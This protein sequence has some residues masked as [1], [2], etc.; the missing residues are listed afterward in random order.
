M[1]TTK[2][3]TPKLTGTENIKIPYYPGC[4]L[5]TTAK[6]FENSAVAAARALGI[7]LLEIPRWNCCGTVFSLTDDDLIHHVA[8]VRNFIRVQEMNDY[9]L[10][11]NENRLVTLC[12][13]CFN[14]LKS[15][16]LRVKNNAE[17][18]K[19]INDLMYREENYGGKVEVLH[20][21]EL[22][23]SLGFE[24]IRDRVK[25]PLKGLKIA[26][27]YGCMILRPQEIGIDDPE[28][29]TIQ[30]DLLLS[31]GADSV[32]TPYKRVC[33]G[34]Y[35]TVKEKNI[36]AELAYDIL[37]HARKE[38]AEAMATV[39]PLCAFNLDHRQ[40]EVKASHSDFEEIPVFYVT[41]LMAIAF[42]LENEC[43][44]FDQNYVDPRPLLASKSLI[45]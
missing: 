4:T 7:E 14:T 40:K 43:Y 28:D 45:K 17:D 22:L 3:E 15:T 32:D 6:N 2:T 37:S 38:G 13:M 30:R 8:S 9:G 18:L 1:T 31:L 24:K 25:K 16:N 35:Q 33:C 42:A 27:Y 20:F 11:K 23:K 26:P 39:C 12:A 36:V 10:V 44:G 34:S 41:Q 19:K 5:K 21:L 29:P